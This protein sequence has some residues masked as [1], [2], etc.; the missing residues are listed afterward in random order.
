MN[1][2]HVAV[3]PSNSQTLRSDKSSLCLTLPFSFDPHCAIK[4]VNSQ[5][6]ARFYA[7]N[8]YDR[9]Y[10]LATRRI[11]RCWKLSS[12]KLRNRSKTSIMSGGRLGLLVYSRKTKMDPTDNP[13]YRFLSYVPVWYRWLLFQSPTLA[14]ATPQ[15]KIW[16]RASR[17]TVFNFL[18]VCT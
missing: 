10:N 7:R 8:F 3:F 4:T 14:L 13:N 1:S 9:S 17:G 15:I 2:I 12:K 18:F 11:L 6:G 16:R 5:T